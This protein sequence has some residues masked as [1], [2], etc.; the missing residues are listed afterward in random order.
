MLDHAYLV[1]FANMKIEC[2]G[3]PEIPLMLG[4]S[5]THYVAMGMQS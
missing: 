2:R 5:G 4:R 1:A 3:W